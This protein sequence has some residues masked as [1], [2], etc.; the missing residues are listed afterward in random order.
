MTAQ[1]ISK[2]KPKSELPP[3]FPEAADAL[4]AQAAVLAA[5]CEAGRDR[6]SLKRLVTVNPQDS[7]WD[8]HLMAALA[9]I[10]H[11]AIPVLLADLFGQAT[12]KARRKGLKRALHLLQT[13]GVPVPGELLPREEPVI[14][15][16]KPVETKTM[17]SPILGNG[18]SVVVLEAP[19]EVLG[20]NFLVSV[21]ND[22]KGLL[23]CHLLILK[24]RQQTE[25]W[26]YYRRQGLSDWFPV[27]G[28][29]AVRLLEA[30]YQRVEM[31]TEASRRYAS[32]REQIW[33]NWGRP[34]EAPDLEKVLPV[35]E[36]GER[37]RLLEQSSQLAGSPLFQSWLPGQEEI[38]PWLEKV[39]EVEQSPL[40]LS[41]QQKAVRA[42]ALL[43]EA[44]RALFP[45]EA[46]P[47]WAR[48]LLAMAYYLELGQ[49]PEEA[50]LAKVAA[51][52]LRQP[53]PTSLGG[54]NPFLQGLVKMAMGLAWQESQQSQE[55]KE[56]GGL[57]TLP[58]ESPLIRR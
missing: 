39:R 29:Y 23:E 21:I 32:V 12:D 51:A 7:L 18:D 48:R 8:L 24:S 27:P 14:G 40:V 6:E 53:E 11:P 38:T 25:F 20:G 55:A 36:P 2:A 16:P 3:L 22:E 46:R 10:N 13:R 57:L 49:R 1:K 56:P 43:A 44:T 4:A 31:A 54:E 15:K 35:L 41:D 9:D 37:S 28:P 52:D 42:G 19:K 33:K 34:E 26:E 58:H 17:V 30:A 47:L 50:H 5:A 45:P